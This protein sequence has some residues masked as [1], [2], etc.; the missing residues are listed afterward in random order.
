MRWTVCT[1]ALGA[2]VVACT[3]AGPRAGAES[4]NNGRLFEALAGS[5][6]GVGSAT[7]NGGA[8]ERVRCRADYEPSSPTQL[9]LS[10]RCAS[11]SFNLQVASDV[12]RQGNRI[13]GNWSESNTGVSGDLSGSAGADRLDAVVDGAGVQ[14]RLNLEVRGNTQNVSLVSQGPLASSTSITLRRE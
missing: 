1:M 10:L 2:A 8:A 11:D 9:R 6:S 3:M 14:A 12:T 13:S 4:P 5:W 7:L